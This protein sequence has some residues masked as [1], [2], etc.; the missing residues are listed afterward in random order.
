[1]VILSVSL[2]FSAPIWSNWKYNR[3]L[4]G[5]CPYYGP[6]NPQL[7]W[8]FPTGDTFKITSAAP[9]I[10]QDGTIYFASPDSFIFAV[11]SNGTEK[12]RYKIGG[13]VPGWG[14]AIDQNGRIYFKTTDCS[15]VAIDDSVTYAK[16]VWKRTF[17]SSYNPGFNGLCPVVLG[18][19]KTIYARFKD[20]LFAIDSLG[21]RKWAFFTPGMSD[22]F[23]PAISPD[24]SFLYFESCLEANPS[25]PN[26]IIK[27]NINGGLVWNYYIGLI[28]FSL[29]WG[30][31]AIGSDGAIY[32]A[33]AR[34]PGFLYAINPDGTTKWPPVS[35]GDFYYMTASL[36]KNDTIWIMT[37]GKRPTYYKFAP[38]N[39]SI[40]F[41]DSITYSPSR[42]NI[43]NSF[44]IDSLGRAFI[45]LLDSG[46]YYTTLYALEPNGTIK[47]TYTITEPRS[48]RTFP[49]L[50]P[51]RFY[52]I[53]GTKLYAFQAE[54]GI[55]WG[56]SKGELS[57]CEFEIMP[58]P[59]QKRTRIMI[60]ALS[61]KVMIYD[62]SGRLVRSLLANS[63][64]GYFRDLVWDGVDDF[65]HELP[66]GV[67][68]VHLE[69]NSQSNMKK[70]VKL[71]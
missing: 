38:D 60:G 66:S 16:L 21:N 28:P 51:G 19:D 46:T 5:R 39:G 9:V 36:G 64:N 67:Y 35:N 71:K 22:G 8:T 32:F 27:L 30:S 24:G 37:F 68:F 13:C 15:V 40:T 63:E 14:P 55:S 61:D 47:W 42:S 25:A 3:Q 48:Y 41:R 44:T 20:S 50:A 18:A 7:L 53:A 43:Y 23:P 34:S 26:Y 70:I 2:V 33:S 69:A 59:F 11:R 10:G 4:T 62:V 65:G 31:P 29:T 56:K 52:I 58:N 17:Y 45:A 49:A 6:V 57:P 54:E 1:M 12:W